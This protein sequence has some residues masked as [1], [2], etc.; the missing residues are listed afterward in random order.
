MLSLAIY[1]SLLG[2]A[3]TAP[4]AHNAVRQAQEPTA[5]IDS[6][7][8][9]GTYTSIAGASQ[10]LVNQ[11]L[12]VPFA[13]SPTRFSP[14]QTPAS[15]SQPYT[16]TQ[17]GPACIQQFNYPEATRNFT[18]EAFNTPAPPESED[19]LSLNIFAPAEAG[20]ATELKSVMFWIYGN[21]TIEFMRLGAKVV[22]GGS[23]QFGW[24]GNAAYD[25]SSFAANQDVIIVSVNY[26]T[27]GKY[28]WITLVLDIHIWQYLAFLQAL[29]FP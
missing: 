2:V 16:A 26:R 6:G 10:T 4:A 21:L 18:I 8:L 14:A 27:N 1:S 23:L 25:G 28:A 17:R 13:A 12:G 19:C 29:N 20:S 9:I 11:F 3:L 22:A 7:V 5:T 24:N 15:W